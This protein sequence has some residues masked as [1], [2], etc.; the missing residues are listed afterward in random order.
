MLQNYVVPAT[1]H[2]SGTRF[3]EAAKIASE[4]SPHPSAAPPPHLQSGKI[5]RVDSDRLGM[6]ERSGRAHEHA[7][8][9]T[10]RKIFEIHIGIFTE[11]AELVVRRNVDE[12]YYISDVSLPVHRH[13][14][15]SQ[16]RG[17]YFPMG[18]KPA[19]IKPSATGVSGRS[20]SRRDI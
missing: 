8:S 3:R 14:G 1:G 13:H 12:V 17:R 5:F 4:L 18:E 6:R 9:P 10:P 2:G 15:W 7:P 20:A 19:E 16:R 11:V